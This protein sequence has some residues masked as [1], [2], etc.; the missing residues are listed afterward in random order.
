[1]KIATL[2]LCLAAALTTSGCLIHHTE[3]FEP[4]HDEQKQERTRPEGVAFAPGAGSGAP[5]ADTGTAR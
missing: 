4:R 3:T 1:M 5:G 2:M